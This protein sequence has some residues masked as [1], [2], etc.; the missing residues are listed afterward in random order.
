[1]IATDTKFVWVVVRTGLEKGIDEARRVQ[2]MI[3]VQGMGPQ[4]L[5]ACCNW[6]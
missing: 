1:M 6:R 5:Y 2:S 3:T 4:R